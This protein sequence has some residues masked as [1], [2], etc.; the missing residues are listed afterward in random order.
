MKNLYLLAF[1]CFIVS[2]SSDDSNS[3]QQQ[4]QSTTCSENTSIFQ[5][6]V[7]LTNQFEVN[8]FGAMC[9]SGINGVLHIES[10][11]ESIPI[12]SL[13]PLSG[14]KEVMGLYVIN[15][16]VTSLEGINLTNQTFLGVLS[17]NNN[18]YLESLGNIVVPS[19]IGTLNFSSNH[20]LLNFIGLEE[21]N[22]IS[23]KLRISVN[24]NITSFSGFNNIE[25]IESFVL[26]QENSLTNFTGL[27]NLKGSGGFFIYDNYSLTNFVGLGELTYLSGISDWGLDVKYNPNLISFDGLENLLQADTLV[28]NNNV[29]LADY[30]GLDNLINNGNLESY[31]GVS[32]CAYNPTLLDMQNGNCSQ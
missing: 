3:V 7:T 23:V 6:N 15:T 32:G 9:Y 2:C 13:L 18:Q 20:N 19:S 11:P 29:N 12:N 25:Y 10:S 1:I 30:C 21:L 28:I 8:D 16:N 26:Q 14:I 24:D 31:P 27:D 4:N 5:G 22:N 17:I